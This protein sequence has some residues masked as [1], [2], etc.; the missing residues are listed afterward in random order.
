[1][2]RTVDPPEKSRRKRIHYGLFLLGVGI[3]CAG[4]V[5]FIPALQYEF[6]QEKS[7]DS[8]E[9]PRV[10]EYEFLTPQEQRIVDGAIN[11]KT[12][13]L[14][15][16]KPLPGPDPVLEAKTIQVSKQGTT[17]TFTSRAVFPAKA[18]KGTATIALVVG[19]LLAM[20][21][22]VRRHHFPNSLPWQTS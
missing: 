2:A 18:P 21:E 7:E 13:R 12:H 17:H 5:L 8:I 3:L 6:T 10:Y 9:E 11:G 16:T 1:M 15:T 22:A 19:G 20:V 14:K 4:I